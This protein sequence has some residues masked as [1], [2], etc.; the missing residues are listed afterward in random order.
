MTPLWIVSVGPGR[1]EWMTLEA[2]ERI[3]SADVIAVPQPRADELALAERVASKFIP[4]K[5]ERLYLELPMSYDQTLLEMRWKEAAE[6]IWKRMKE[7]RQVALLVLGDASLFGT[8]AYIV[9]ELLAAHPEAEI[10]STPGVI[11][12]TACASRLGMPLAVG[13]QNVTIVPDSEVPENMDRAIATGGTV[14]LM[15]I[16]R[17]IQHVIR[18]L[19]ERNLLQHARCV[20]KG[21]MPEEEIV[22]DL[23]ALQGKSIPYM[24]LIVLKVPEGPETVQGGEVAIAPFLH[25]SAPVRP[26]KGGKVLLVGF[27][28]GNREHLTY[29]ARQAILSADV[30]VGYV[31]YLNLI[32]ELLPGKEIIRGGMT[33]EVSRA[34][35]AVEKAREGKVVALISSGDAGVYGMA[36]PTYEVLMEAGWTP[37]EPPE[38]EVVPGVTAL[39]AVASVLGAPLAHDFCAISL[40]DLLTP[41]EVIEKRLSA[42]AESDLITG[43]YNP[44]SGRRTKQLMRAQEIFLQ[45]RDPKTPVGI[46]KSCLRR[47]QT[48]NLTTLDGMQ[49]YDIGMLTTVLIGNAS[50]VAYKGLM[51]TPRGYR[52]KYRL[53]TG[54]VVEGVKAAPVGQQWSLDG[55]EESP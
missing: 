28:P 23:K 9:Q 7:G 55:G 15:K 49:N 38:V 46:V 44:K 11:S 27:G 12:P 24:S 45:C 18:H 1:P 50:T 43:L 19:E 20:I 35:T 17:S 40:S 54:N 13:N 39:N 3:R 52:R 21:G 30:V 37:G 41:W 26:A 22:P 31:T 8:S 29:R 42:A 51:V 32:K 10:Q 5:A 47:R 14:V 53:G 48:V 6:A 36:A 34:I 2:V 25:A 33:E 16:S 4:E